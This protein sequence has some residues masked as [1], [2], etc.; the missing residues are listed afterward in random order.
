MISLDNR[1]PELPLLFGESLFSVWIVVKK[2]A[3]FFQKTSFRIEQ[4]SFARV[5]LSAGKERTIL[6]RI[7]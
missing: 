6:S 1:S 5:S 7:Q 3:D 4:E 2:L